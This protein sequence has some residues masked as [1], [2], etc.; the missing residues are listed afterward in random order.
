MPHFLNLFEVKKVSITA[1]SENS[2][3]ILIV[4]NRELIN[5]HVISLR[6]TVYSHPNTNYK[7]YATK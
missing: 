5:R 6:L 1:P 3:D 2:W 4:Q 7:N